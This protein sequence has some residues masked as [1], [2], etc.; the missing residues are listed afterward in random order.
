MAFRAKIY[1]SNTDVLTGIKIEK[2][3]LTAV[4]I[5]KADVVSIEF[6]NLK[7]LFSSLEVTSEA[8]N[9][10]S[11]GEFIKN[12]SRETWNL[13]TLPF[14]YNHTENSILSQWKTLL[15]KKFKWL[16]IYE[17]PYRP[18]ELIGIYNK[19]IAVNINNYSWSSQDGR[20]SLIVSLKERP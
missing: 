19:L 5:A 2:Y 1:A 18:T 14:N 12:V 9:Y 8:K 6:D 11:G 7:G 4:V 20:K 3:P 15:N 13:E 16:E 10:W 17:Y